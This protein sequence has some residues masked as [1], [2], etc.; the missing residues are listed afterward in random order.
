[1]KNKWLVVMA[2]SAS[3]ASAGAF[4][5]NGTMGD[6]G[7]GT[8]STTTVN[9][10]GAGPTNGNGIGRGG[11]GVTHGNG[12]GMRGAA[13]S[14][15]FNSLDRGHKGYLTRSDVASD[16]QIASHFSTCDKNKNGKLSRTE[17][18]ACKRKYQ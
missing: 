1:M 6:S 2:V 17:F 9:P 18:R 4:A 13:G 7:N 12:G 10:G 14:T 15:S 3:L 16:P 5:A 8:T 11:T